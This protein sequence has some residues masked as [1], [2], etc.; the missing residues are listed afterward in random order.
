MVFFFQ[1]DQHDQQTARCFP[2]GIS[3]CL[4]V[5]MTEWLPQREQRAAARGPRLAALPQ[6][7]AGLVP[8]FPFPPQQLALRGRRRSQFLAPAEVRWGE[9]KGEKRFV[10]V[11]KSNNA[12]KG[13]RG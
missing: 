13:Q 1:S 7:A 10:L 9:E 3:S 5:F 8:A 2:S 12:S 4:L 11:T 6:L